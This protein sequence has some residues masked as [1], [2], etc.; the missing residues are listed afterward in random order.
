M[1]SWKDSLSV[2]LYIS[3]EVLVYVCAYIFLYI[4]MHICTH[5]Y[6]D[7]SVHARRDSWIVREIARYIDK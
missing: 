2:Y 6:I 1:H 4:Y 7:K 3:I 5:T